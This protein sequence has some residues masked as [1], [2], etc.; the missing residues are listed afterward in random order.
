MT[1]AA[2]PTGPAKP[3][4]RWPRV[5]LG[6]RTNFAGLVWLLLCV[7]CAVLG[8]VAGR[9]WWFGLASGTLFY[10]GVLVHETAHGLVGHVG[11]RQPWR[12]LVIGDE[13]GLAAAYLDEPLDRPRTCRQQ[14]A[15]SA[16][17]PIA[18]ALFGLALVIGSGGFFL[19]PGMLSVIDGLLQLTLP[20]QGNDGKKVLTMLLRVM[21]GH[22]HQ[23]WQ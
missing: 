5:S 1:E 6:R 12:A 16:A 8:A 21:R 3:P 22:G 7:V 23:P 2:S 20:I 11:C 19:A 13:H 9:P 4:S 15:I 10:L 14:L 18:E 17:G